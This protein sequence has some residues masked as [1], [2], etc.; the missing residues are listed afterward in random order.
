[1]TIDQIDLLLMNLLNLKP[2]EVE[3]ISSS[4]VNGQLTIFV[5]IAKPAQRVCPNCGC[6]RPVSKGFYSKEIRLSND[7]FRNAKVIVKVPRYRC[8]DCNSSYSDDRHMSPAGYSI[9]YEVVIRIMDLLK[10]PEI[11]M[12]RCAE[13]V[14]VSET[15]VVRTFDKH[16]HVHRA[17]FPEALCI[18]EVYTK[19]NDFKN[20][21]DSYSK[22]SCLL[23]DFYEHTLVDVLPS[24]TKNYLSHYLSSIPVNERQGVKFVVI[25]MY[26]NYRDM[27]KIY[28]KRAVICVDSFHVIEHLN[29]SLSKVRIRVMK[30]YDS[31]SQ[32]Y[33]LL[34]HW[35]NLLFDRNR[36]LHNKGKYNKKM[37]RV[38]NYFQIREALLDIHP[39]LKNAWILKE[40]YTEFN[41][42]CDYEHAN[43]RLTEILQR[44][45]SADIPEYR[46]FSNTVL[47]WK[48]YIVN[49]FMK[50]KGRRVNNGVA[51][52]INAR[53]KLLLYNTRGMRN[54]E[55]R[56]KRILYAINKK[57]FTLK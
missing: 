37:G 49:S 22:Y 12:A 11:T 38:M 7:A 55:R 9:S 41:I 46:D 52:S 13:L 17:V 30:M 24:R 15:T 27:A 6:I 26:R 8:P 48:P 19:L 16:C 21:G 10:N 14:G 50:Y 42:S 23:Y 32:E 36:E 47:E 20:Y 25:D 53:V 33:Y 57:G 2:H 3:S 54:S 39:D 40:M 56:R 1:M 4:S 43:E 5:T 29:N 31:D 51:E 44:F 45:Y 28:F 35:N 18:D 34:K